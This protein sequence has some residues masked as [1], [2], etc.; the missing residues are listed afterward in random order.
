MKVRAQDELKFSCES[1]SVRG[2]GVPSVNAVGV[3]PPP[4]PLERAVLS[5]KGL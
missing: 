4:P 3:I 5:E 1:G 2:P